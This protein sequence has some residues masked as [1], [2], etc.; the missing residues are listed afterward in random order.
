MAP[1][2]ALLLVARLAL[3]TVL[4]RRID[5]TLELLFGDDVMDL[6][7]TNKKVIN[8]VDMPFAKDAQDVPGRKKMKGKGVQRQPRPD[9]EE[10]RGGE[11]VEAESEPEADL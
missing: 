4:A 6:Y 8:K 1:P 7:S 10:S 2:L 3:G 9:G 5:P 11:G